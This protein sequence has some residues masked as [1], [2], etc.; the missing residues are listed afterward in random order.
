DHGF[1]MV[2]TTYVPEILHQHLPDLIPPRL[3]ESGLGMEAVRHWAVHP[4][5]RAILDKVAQGL[6]LAD[7]A[8]DAPRRVLNQYGN[9]SSATI[10]FVLDEVRRSGESGPVFAM[11]FGPGLTVETAVLHL[12]A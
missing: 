3:Q 11:A 10:G 4:G 2:L 6:G 7:D 8:L 5:G 12:D 1:D 9:M